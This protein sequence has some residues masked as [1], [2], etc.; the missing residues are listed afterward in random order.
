MQN[1]NKLDHVLNTSIDEWSPSD[2]L[3]E[4]KRREAIP[5]DLNHRLVCLRQTCFEDGVTCVSFHYVTQI[6]ALT[7]VRYVCLENPFG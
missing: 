6:D 7:G 5:V 3:L 4:E 2:F 1:K